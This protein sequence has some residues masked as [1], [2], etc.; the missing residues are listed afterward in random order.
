MNNDLIERYIYAVTKRLPSKI[1]KDVSKELNSL[2]YD[3]LDERCGDISP[4][5]KDIRVVLTELGTPSELAE[6]YNP[7]KDKCLIGSPY[8]SQY[9]MLLKIVLIAAVSGTFLAKV[10]N[11]ILNSN[12]QPIHAV[13]DIIFSIIFCAVLAFAF[14]TLIFAVL[15]HKKIKIG[16]LNES[17]DNLPPVPSDSAKI[18]KADFIVGIV[19]SLIFVIIFIG[20]PQIIGFVNTDNQFISFLDTDAIHSSWYIILIFALTGIIKEIIKL[21]EGTY[22]IK[23]TLAVVVDDV[24]SGITAVVWL[25]NFKIVN[26]EFTNQILLL[27]GSS[28]SNAYN[29]VA[30]LFD[31]FN[32]IFLAVMMFALTLEC[33]I[34]LVKYVR[35][36]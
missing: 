22:T 32:Y 2:I 10:I 24:I 35:N 33:V 14:V 29:V 19:V 36:K 20:A 25:L 1:R 17:L 9:I 21:V 7:D 8:Y 27:T 30:K 12:T 13:F 16:T 4:T 15:Y 28:D 26:P 23:A 31:N 5:E 34:A 18:S 6:Q 11:Y 3:M